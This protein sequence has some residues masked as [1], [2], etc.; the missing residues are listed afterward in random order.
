[1]NPKM[2]DILCCPVCQ[3]DVVLSDYEIACVKCHL[4]YPIEDGIPVMLAE[5]ARKSS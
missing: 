5:R 3:G 2:F 1:M 4:R